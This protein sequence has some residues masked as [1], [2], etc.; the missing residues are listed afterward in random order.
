MA[1]TLLRVSFFLVTGVVTLTLPPPQCA[2]GQ[3]VPPFR[4]ACN[5]PLTGELATYGSAVQEGSLMAFDELSL[6]KVLEFDWQDNSSTPRGAASI[7][8]RQLERKPHVYISGIK[9]QYMAIHDAVMKSGIPHFPWIFDMRI[10]PNGERNFRTCINFKIEPPLFLDFAAK[11]KASKVAVIYVQLPHTDEEYN[12]TIIPGLE[13]QGAEV[14]VERYDMNKM[15]FRDLAL[16][17][18]RFRPDVLV[19]SGFQ[20]N[21]TGMVKALRQLN[22][23]GPDNTVATYDMADTLPLLSPEETEGIHVSAP[24][25][26]L[27]PTKKYEEWKKRFR[28]RF[29]KEPLYLHA[30]AYDMVQLIAGVAAQKNSPRDPAGIARALQNAKVD[31]ITGPVSFDADGDAVIPVELGIVRNGVLTASGKNS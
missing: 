21:F 26:M 22:L 1:G 14:L 13:A 2:S 5:L 30:Y 8:P 9:P 29:K 16:R 24:R 20:A 15:D 25:F 28:L 12:G 4:I 19:L 11:R 7:A 18:A 6:G 23:I 31:G 10:R 17:V 27:H 3:T